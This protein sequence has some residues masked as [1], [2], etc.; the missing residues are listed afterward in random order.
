MIVVEIG[1]CTGV[2]TVLLIG[3][4]CNPTLSKQ[5]GLRSVLWR[6]SSSTASLSFEGVFHVDVTQL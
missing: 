3:V 2:M 6:V 1:W 5:I 4:V